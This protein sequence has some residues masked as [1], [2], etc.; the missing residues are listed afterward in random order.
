[1]STETDRPVV[2]TTEETQEAIQTDEAPP[3]AP[4]HETN[5]RWRAE[6]EIA[7]AA[8]ARRE[9]EAAERIPGMEPAPAPVAEVA[10]TEA[11]PATEAEV[12]AEGGGRVE[13][14]AKAI[15]PNAEYDLIIDG[16]P[17][18]VKASQIMETGQRA[19]QKEL[20]AD[21]RLEL[22]T[23]MLEEAKRRAEG[24]PPV[25]TGAQPTGKT[26]SAPTTGKSDAELAHLIQYGTQEQAGEAIAEI[27]RR[28]SSTVTQDSLQEFIV[29]QLPAAVSSQ[30]AF[31]QAVT[32]AKDEYKDIFADPH[33]TTLF[34][35]QEHQARQAGDVRSH[36]DLYK[37]IGDG[38]RSHFKLAAPTKANGPTIA[39]KKVAK[40]A[41][42]SV[43]KLASVRIETPGG[44]PKTPEEVRDGVLAKMKAA[45][46]QGKL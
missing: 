22:A 3:P 15:D 38:I 12:P 34:H 36:S 23:R 2:P 4:A 18:K 25:P 37:A 32:S 14:A 33:L 11:V 30:L 26:E 44:P 16:K 13:E 31:H 41:A 29:Q 20:A 7:A 19:L 42:P 8:A 24:Q 40:A 10:T 43:P 9:A 28:D 45:R 39:E 27:R 1:M 5:P 46:G 21:Q 35:V 6:K 17:V